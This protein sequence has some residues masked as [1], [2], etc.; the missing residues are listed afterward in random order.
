MR[1]TY[2]RLANSPTAGIVVY[3]IEKSALG[4]ID[5]ADG[6]DYKQGRESTAYQ[7]PGGLP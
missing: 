2:M 3:L 6:M 7:G 1:D 4:P 5:N